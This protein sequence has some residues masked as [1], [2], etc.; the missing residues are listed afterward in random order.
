[1][2]SKTERQEGMRIEME[3]GGVG[4]RRIED[5]NVK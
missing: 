4:K 3:I 1:M 5:A 2:R